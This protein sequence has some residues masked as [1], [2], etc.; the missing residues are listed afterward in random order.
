MSLLSSLI[1]P[2]T[3]RISCRY[4]PQET[5]TEVEISD[6]PRF[7]VVGYLH[8]Q[9]RFVTHCVTNLITNFSEPK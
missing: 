8:S 4:W 3:S 2:R 9:Y 5:G 6:D 7:E 1:P